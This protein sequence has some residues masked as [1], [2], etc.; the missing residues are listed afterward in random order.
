MRAASAL[1]ALVDLERYPIGDLDGPDALA[2]AERCRAE[3]DEC[4]PHADQSGST[5]RG[6]DDHLGQRPTV[7]HRQLDA[8]SGLR[9]PVDQ[10]SH[11]DHAIRRRYRQRAQ[12]RDGLVVTAVEIS[13][14][15]GA[16]HHEPHEK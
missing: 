16:L 6:G 1:E 8:R 9:A 2:L 11:E 5:P 4:F 13:D 14:D 15:D 3:L 7:L 10:V 12:Q